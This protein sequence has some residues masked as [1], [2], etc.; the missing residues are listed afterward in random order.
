MICH[1]VVLYK[2]RSRLMQR[3]NRWNSD[4]MNFSTALEWRN[5]W[6]EMRF[7]LLDLS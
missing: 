1:N 3:Y 2:V 4:C 6:V 5:Q 7:C